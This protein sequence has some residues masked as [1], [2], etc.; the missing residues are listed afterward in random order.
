MV[1]RI[2]VL[3]SQNIHNVIHS[4][5]PVRS[6]LEVSALSDVVQLVAYLVCILSLSLG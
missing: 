3:R 5:V 2:V 6:L 1:A 4:T